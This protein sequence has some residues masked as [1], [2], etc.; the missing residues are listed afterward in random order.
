MRECLSDDCLV[1][2]RH[3]AE[4]GKAITLSLLCS[5]CCRYRGEVSEPLIIV[6]LWV[7]LWMRVVTQGV[8]ISSQFNLAHDRVM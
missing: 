4:G 3:N 6:A 1:P 8:T 2:R 7:K 5:D